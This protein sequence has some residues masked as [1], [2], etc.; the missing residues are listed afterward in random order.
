MPEKTKG[1]LVNTANDFYR[2]TQFPNCNG[3]VDG[4]HIR[5]KIPSRSRSPLYNYRRFFSILILRSGSCKLLFYRGR[6]WSSK[7]IGIE[8]TV[9]AGQQAVAK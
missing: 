1:D 7:K 9:N 8:S 5:I 4:K 3:V 6:R 2:R